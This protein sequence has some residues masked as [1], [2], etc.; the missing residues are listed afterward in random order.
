MLGFQWPLKSFLEN[1]Y[2]NKLIDITN[3]GVAGQ[4]TTQGLLRFGATIVGRTG[5]VCLS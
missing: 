5:L 1:C 3:N 4:T 2:T